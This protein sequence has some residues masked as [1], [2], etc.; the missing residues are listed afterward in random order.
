MRRVI[1]VDTHHPLALLPNSQELMVAPEDGLL[2][3]YHA[4][5]L[6]W[7]IK[8]RQD[9][10]YIRDPIMLRYA[11]ALEAAV[12]HRLINIREMTPLSHDRPLNSSSS[13]F[14]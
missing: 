14:V 2:H 10:Q 5:P 12:H 4:E 8:L 6:E 1:K 7:F 9:Y 13:S 3:D 11:D